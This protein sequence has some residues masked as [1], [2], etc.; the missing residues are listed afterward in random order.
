MPLARTTGWCPQAPPHR[1]YRVAMVPPR[2]I[3]RAVMGGCTH[4]LSSR[5]TPTASAGAYIAV[6]R[7]TYHRCI[8][9]TWHPVVSYSCT[10]YIRSGAPMRVASSPVGT[11]S[12]SSEHKVGCTATRH[13]R[14]EV[15]NT[16]STVTG[17]GRIGPEAGKPLDD[18]LEQLARTTGAIGDVGA[19]A[20]HR[21]SRQA[22]RQPRVCEAG[23]P[24]ASIDQVVSA[25]AAMV[26][27]AAALSRQR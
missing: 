27:V 23:P 3:R 24:E 15:H 20:H 16:V 17:N 4:D 22:V 25:P 11:P 2:L 6:S 9:A 14:I 21:E 8:P 18:T 5:C 12:R 26:P 19:S 7:G 1:G 13:R 10:A